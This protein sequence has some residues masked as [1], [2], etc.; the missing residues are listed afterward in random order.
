MTD[1]P[2]QQPAAAGPARRPATSTQ[3]ARA[4]GVSRTTVSF[5][6]NNVLDKG[7]SEATRAKVLRVA[8]ELGYQP[9]AAAQS[10]ASG[11][12]G[13]VALVIPRASRLSDDPS[14]SQLVASVNQECHRISLK[15]LLESS[16]H[17][18][19]QVSSFVALVRTRRIDGLV[20]VGP[21]RSQFD[22]LQGLVTAGIPMVVL[23]SGSPQL[24]TCC[25][26][27]PGARSF[28]HLAVGHLIALG[29]RDIA[30][31]GV[32]GP[33]YDS[34]A[35]RE[36]DW[37]NTLVESGLAADE[38]LLEFGDVT[39]LSGYQATRRLLARGRRFTALFAGNDSIAFGA[40][41]AL[42][43]AGLRIPEDVAMVGYDDIPLAE[44]ADPPLTTVRT[45]ATAQ[46]RVAMLE[47]A[48]LLGLGNQPVP[49]VPSPVL[50]VRASCGAGPWSPES[51]RL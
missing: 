14:L 39:A 31:V 10:L 44:F 50:V 6:L 33:E 24:D 4:A 26:L 49:E 17:D 9:N 46:G 36:R 48:R 43:E 21:H 25:S 7:I 18:T 41:R 8:Q 23:G 27:G 2:R 37:R 51:S 22:H 1:S 30:H 38:A 34:G 40:L 29:H 32:T 47:L 5:V 12:T 13:T 16:E 11:S 19:D 42:R 45:D 3:V 28:A 15:L 20:V 35:S